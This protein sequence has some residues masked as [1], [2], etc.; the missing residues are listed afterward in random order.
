MREP[1]LDLPIPFSA[2]MILGLLAGRKLETRRV[3]QDTPDS[4]RL[5]CRGCGVSEKEFKNARCQC[6]TP[7]FRW[8]PCAHARHRIGDRLY[9]REGIERWL[10]GNNR[11]MAYVRFKADG[12]AVLHHWPEH[13]TR[14]SAVPMHMPRNISRM[15]LP[16]T[17]VRIERLHNITDAGAI[18]EGVALMKD[19][20]DWQDWHVPGVD[21]PNKDFPYLARTTPRE[22]YAALWDTINGSGKW[23]ANPWV[24]VTQWGKVIH[25]NIDSIQ[26]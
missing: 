1:N 3:L 2:P 11:G 9:V 14:F 19:H 21:H 18:A 4:E 7:D 26:S 15:T 22:M 13:W 5:M 23:L 17:G 10:S 25:Q 6:A 16:V 24:A 20:G 12:L 8:T